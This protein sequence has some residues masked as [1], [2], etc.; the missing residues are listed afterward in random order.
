MKVT[1]KSGESRVLSGPYTLSWWELLPGGS[2]KRAEG[3][4]VDWKGDPRFFK[5]EQVQ[6]MTDCFSWEQSLC[7]GPFL[8]LPDTDGFFH[9]G[10]MAVCRRESLKPGRERAALQMTG[11]VPMSRSMIKST[12]WD[13]GLKTPEK[14]RGLWPLQRNRR[15]WFTGA[16]W[17]VTQRNTASPQVLFSYGNFRFRTIEVPSSLSSSKGKLTNL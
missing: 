1:G 15:S 9:L 6:R 8:V 16:Q 7:Q 2:V 11:G 5:H 3:F 14:K 13:S 17:T 4:V 10:R 12:K